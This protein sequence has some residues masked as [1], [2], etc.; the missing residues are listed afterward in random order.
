MTAVYVDRVVTPAASVVATACGIPALN[1]AQQCQGEEEQKTL[2]EEETSLNP[3]HF[4]DVD[5]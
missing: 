5:D 1:K 3:S 2:P 4:A